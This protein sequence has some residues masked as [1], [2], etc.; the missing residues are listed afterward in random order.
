MTRILRKAS[1]NSFVCVL[2][3]LLSV[4]A[5]VAGQDDRGG[6]RG[7]T[8]YSRGGYVGGWQHLGDARV[9]GRADYD[10]IDIDNRGTFSALALGVTGGAVEF[11]RMVIRFRNGGEEVLPVGSV[12]RSGG[13]TPPIP[14]RGGPR[15]IRNVE[16]WYRKGAYNQGAPTV[17]LFG[18]R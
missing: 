17:D 14:F 6:A 1:G 16:V 13:R 4:P 3:V 9:D 5:L 7:H 11:Q 2:C 18:R 12:V 8:A 10:K 15:E